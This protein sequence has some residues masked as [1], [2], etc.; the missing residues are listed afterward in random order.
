VYLYARYIV[1]PHISYQILI[2]SVHAYARS[3]QLL[4]RGSVFTRKIQCHRT[5][6]SGSKK[7]LHLIS[8]KKSA[9]VA[10]RNSLAFF[11]LIDGKRQTEKREKR[12][13]R[14]RK[15]SDR[16]P[17]IE[18]AQLAYGAQVEALYMSRCVYRRY[19][20]VCV[21]HTRQFVMCRII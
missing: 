17:T 18:K 15:R 14:K 13:R 6:R 9:L 11:L 5:A 2:S 19:N 4:I 20:Y 1:L 8:R 10:A 21:H 3:S 16:V 7:R 12:K